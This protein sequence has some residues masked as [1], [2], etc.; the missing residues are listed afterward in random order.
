MLHILE[1]ASSCLE[2]RL[3]PTVLIVEVAVAV[4]RFNVRAYGIW[5]NSNAEVLVSEEYIQGRRIVKFPG[6]GLEYGEGLTECLF[7]EWQ[8][9]TGLEIEIIRHYYT[10][11]FF[12]PS[13]FNQAEQVL[14]IYYLV[15][16]VAANGHSMP[17]LD[18]NGADENIRF[19]WVS[20]TQLSPE[21]FTLPIDK[22]VAD[23]LVHDFGE[24]TL[25]PVN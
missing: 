1:P 8:E 11:D 17:K 12:Q 15:R 3:Y 6:G 13:A 24:W 5:L 7:R 23:K 10:T 22:V 20:I 16:P 18:E 9:E 21:L 14:S 19:S 2:A 25:Y 4:N